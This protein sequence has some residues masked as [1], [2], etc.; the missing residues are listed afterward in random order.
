MEQDSLRP[1]RLRKHK[2]GSLFARPLSAAIG[3]KYRDRAV[4]DHRAKDVTVGDGVMDADSR[5]HPDR[6]NPDHRHRSSPHHALPQR[7]RRW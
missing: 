6:S 2:A 3:N 1:E 5:D 7:D 4:C